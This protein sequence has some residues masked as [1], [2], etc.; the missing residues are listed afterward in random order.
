MIRYT[1]LGILSLMLIGLLNS[2]QRQKPLATDNTTQPHLVAD[3]GKHVRVYG[4]DIDLNV[5]L[6]EYIPSVFQDSRGDMWFA[7]NGDGVARQHNNTLT[8][9]TPKEGYGDMMARD[10]VE[11]H[12]GNLWFGTN[13]G[14]TRYDGTAFT[15]FTPNDGLPHPHVWSLLV[16]KKG[17]LWVG[18]EG[19]VCRF[20]GMSFE[21]FD[22]P[23][24]KVE[25]KV[26]AY[27]AYK[28]VNN[29]IEDR[30]GNIWF[31]TNGNGVFRYDGKALTQLN[32]KDG[33]RS[34]FVQ[35]VI[36]DKNGGMW[37]SML[38]GGVCRYDGKTFTTFDTRDGLFTEHVWTVFEDQ[39][40]N[41]WIADRDGVLRYDGKTFTRL[42]AK[43]GLDNRFV[44]SMMQD[45]KGNIWFGTSGGAYRYFYD[46]KTIRHFAK[47]AA[48]GKGC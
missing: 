17:T 29:M 35:T 4:P 31:A 33:L 38:Y 3:T 7:T 19:G 30:D 10:I 21:V 14:V 43:D 25:I 6:S 46:N 28:L 20:N 8:Y 13:E 40:A 37:F 41:I 39:D 18:T 47:G 48:I 2:C 24:V 27:P 5:A 12:E 45:T 1:A 15:N 36:Q 16:D 26:E 34:N 23:F 42:N 11:D 32:E 44:Q 9:F 22:L